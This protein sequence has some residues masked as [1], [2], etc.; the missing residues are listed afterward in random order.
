MQVPS[1]CVCGVCVCVYIYIY[2]YTHTLFT[3]TRTHMLHE[4]TGKDMHTYITHKRTHTQKRQSGGSKRDSR[5]VHAARGE[6]Q[7]IRRFPV[8]RAAEAAAVNQPRASN[9]EAGV[10]VCM[11]IMQT[12]M[13]TCN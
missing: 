4:E 11:Y 8:G 5:D 13:H 3:H 9:M 2:I 7:G 1:V 6:G 10:Y 12:Y